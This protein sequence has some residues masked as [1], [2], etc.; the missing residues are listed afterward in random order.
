MLYRIVKRILDLL[1]SVF[2]WIL[3]SPLMFLIAVLIKVS[4]GGEVFV[5]TPVRHGIDGKSFFMYK[6]RTMIPNAHNE[7]M[8]NGNVR[9]ELLSNHKLK[10]DSRVTKIG[11]VLRNT[12]MDEL[13]QLINVILGQMS[14]VGPRPFYTE[15]ISSHLEKYPDDVK[16]FEEILKIKPGLTGVWQVSGRNEIGFKD[17]LDMDMEY[18]HNPNIFRDILILLKTPWVVISRKGVKGSNV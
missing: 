11:R 17:R 5:G 2:L 12:D 14:M 1:L 10:E 6:F 15:E 4:D 16:Y 9:D 7:A 3:T 8:I 13:P 18:A